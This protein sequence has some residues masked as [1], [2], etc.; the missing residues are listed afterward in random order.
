MVEGTVVSLQVC[1]GHRQPMDFKEMVM[2]VTGRGLQGDRHANPRSRRQVLLME[3]EVLDELD[4]TPGAVREN[5][6]IS[7][8]PIHQLAQGQIIGIGDEVRLDVTGLCEPCERM[9]EIRSGLRQAITGRRGVLTR[10]VQG[11]ALRVG[12]GVRVPQ[13][14]PAAL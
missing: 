10:V 7:G 6:T 2:A 8:L 11:G 12:D 9:D 5:V 4:L 14:E 1:V 13:G 3:Q